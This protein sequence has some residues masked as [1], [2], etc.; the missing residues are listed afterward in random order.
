MSAYIKIDTM[1]WPRH[2]GDVQL[3]HPDWDDSQPLP[4]GWADLDYPPQPETEIYFRRELQ[5]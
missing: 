2:P 4:A 3:E 5:I 1:E